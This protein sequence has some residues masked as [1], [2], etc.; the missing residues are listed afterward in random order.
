MEASFT[1]KIWFKNWPEGVPKSVEIPN[2]A[3]PELLKI[4]A[5]KYGDN[6]AIIFYDNR[7]SYRVLNESADKFAAALQ[8][9]G[10]KKGD[11][12]ALFLPNVP[13]F[14][15]SYYGGLRAGAVLVP[16]SPLYKERELKHQLED[17]GVETV[18]AL[19]LLYQVVKNIRESSKLKNIIVTSVRDYLPPLKRM[20]APLKGIKSLKFPETL[21]FTD[22]ISKQEPK[23]STVKIDPE[24]DLA[25]LQYTGGTTGIPKGAMLSHRNIMANAVQ[26]ADWLSDRKIA[27]EIFLSV[28]PFFHIYGMT[29]SMNTPVYTAS[30]MILQPRF[31][32]KAV[33]EAISKYRPTIFC[34]VPTM[35]I[36][37]INHPE[38]GKHNL[39][40]IRACISGAAA[41]PAEVMKRWDEITKGSLVEG[42]GL[43]EAS[44]VTHCNPLYKGKKGGAIG[45]PFPDTE[46]KIVDV[47][48]GADL[49]IGEIGE[50]AVKGPQVMQ[51]YYN[52]PEETAKTM[53]DGWLHTGDVGK[54]DE[55]GYFYIVDR[56]KDMINVSGFKVWPRE[57]EDILYEHPAV[58]AAAVI[59]VYDEYKGEAVKAFIVL[60]DGY[61][62]KTTPEEIMK[63][64]K[65]RVASYK[66]PQLIEF[67]KEL[68]MTPIGKILRRVLTEEE[69]EKI[70]KK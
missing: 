16:C 2:I 3:V 45:I 49:S 41:L 22:L 24:K 25:L 33:L 40:S 67:R 4:A 9:L 42:Y 12:V 35:Y 14:V 21:S 63:F 58:K 20:L 10:V 43:T 47:K 34:G 1:E 50:V 70:V 48:T 30:T 62:G 6:T 37:L 57:V 44:P 64:V 38:V 31:E 51:G 18:I 39:T 69:K 66:A 53:R 36:A 56:K 65:E 55:D 68:P 29:T 17:A 7:I 60:K 8:K 54:T 15:I 32:A 11:R 61:E 5:E 19:D 13:Q 23:P 26:V 46:A 27:G 59:G 52:K 28:L